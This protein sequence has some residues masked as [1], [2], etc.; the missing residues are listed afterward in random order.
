[1]I[2]N[3]RINRF[4]LMFVLANITRLF[5]DENMAVLFLLSSLIAEVS[6]LKE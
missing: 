1:M 6:L 5:F 2:K 3:E 4:F